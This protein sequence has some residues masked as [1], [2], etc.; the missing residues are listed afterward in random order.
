MFAKK[1]SPLPSRNKPHL[2]LLFLSNS[3]LIVFDVTLACLLDVSLSPN[4]RLMTLTYSAR[5]AICTRP[6]QSQKKK[7]FRWRNSVEREEE[8][9]SYYKEINREN[10]LMSTLDTTDE[11]AHGDGT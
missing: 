9:K 6:Q 10:Q 3:R 8:E 1:T 4:H 2:T 11:R 7:Q 5:Q